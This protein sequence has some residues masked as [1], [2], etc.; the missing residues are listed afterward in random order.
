MLENSLRLKIITPQKIILDENVYQVT[1]PTTAGVITI[2]P[3]HLNYLSQLKAG[4]I[5][6]KKLSGD[7]NPLAVLAIDRGIIEVVDN[8]V[9]LLINVAEYVTEISLAA[10]KASLEEAQKRASEIMALHE[11][12]RT[13]EDEEYLLWIERIRH[14]QARIDLVEKYLNKKSLG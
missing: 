8:Q 11:G 1:V 12:E 9:N 4:E 2:L 3:H 10:A 5:M 13:V 7:K 6:V 14:Q